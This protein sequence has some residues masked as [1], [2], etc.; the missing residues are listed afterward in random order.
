MKLKKLNVRKKSVSTLDTL[1]DFQD[2]EIC[3]IGKIFILFISNFIK[4]N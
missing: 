3:S 1:D 2:D 4:I